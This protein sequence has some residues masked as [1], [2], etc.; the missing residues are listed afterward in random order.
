MFLVYHLSS[1]N[2]STPPKKAHF[3][4]LMKQD[5]TLMSVMWFLSH[6]C[7]PPPRHCLL[8]NKL[9]CSSCDFLKRG[10]RNTGFLSRSSFLLSLRASW[11]AP[12][13]QRE[14]ESNKIIMLLKL[15]VIVLV[16]AVVFGKFSPS[17]SCITVFISIIYRI[18]IYIVE[19]QLQLESVMGGL[20]MAET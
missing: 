13:V 15:F 5:R 4:S 1:W 12:L 2:S 7:V 20:N 18:L 6:P 16:A 19:V 8:G 17:V 3:V 11:F 9:P 10:F 14:T